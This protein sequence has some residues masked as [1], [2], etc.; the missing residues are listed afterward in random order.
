MRMEALKKAYAEIILNT[1]KEAA[2][3]VMAAERKALCFHHDLVSL[4]EESLRMFLRL[5]ENFNSKV[6]SFGFG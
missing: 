1:S 4:K 3:R 2:T 6:G 5:K